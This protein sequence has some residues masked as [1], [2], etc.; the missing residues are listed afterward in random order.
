MLY[1]G[2]NTVT[3]DVT[4]FLPIILQLCLTF[5]VTTI[6]RVEFFARANRATINFDL[7]FSEC[8]CVAT[9]MIAAEGLGRVKE[10]IDQVWLKS[11]V[12]SGRGR[13]DMNELYIQE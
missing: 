11:M 2:K 9:R 13:H 10:A 4:A 3:V 5:T 12:I 6:L 1:I 8:A 7:P